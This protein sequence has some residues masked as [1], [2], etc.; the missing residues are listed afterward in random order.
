MNNLK[1]STQNIIYN[2]LCVVLESRRLGDYF[3]WMKIRTKFV[4][5]VELKVKQFKEDKSFD[6]LRCKR[7]QVTL[8]VEGH[9]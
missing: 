1:Y 9:L 5:E 8:E 2:V 7:C 6:G 3:I 4:I